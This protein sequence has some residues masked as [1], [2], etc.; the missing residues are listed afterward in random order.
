M[1]TDYLTIVLALQTSKDLL[2]VDVAGFWRLCS[3]HAEVL[4]NLSNLS[5]MSLKEWG[6]VLGLPV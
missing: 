3:L 1:P 2:A 4:G 6:L 5:G